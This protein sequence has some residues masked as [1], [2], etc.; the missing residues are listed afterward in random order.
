[1]QS[2][3][4]NRLDPF[5]GQGAGT[6][7]A[8]G[9][10]RQSLWASFLKPLAPLHNCRTTGLQGFGN[11]PVGQTLRS[12]QADACTQ[13]GPLGTSFGRHPGFQ[14]FAILFR[15]RQFFGWVPHEPMH[16]TK[17]DNCKDIIVTLH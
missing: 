2:S 13:D 5:G 8:G 12:L 14:G 15:Y 6:Q 11:G 17:L 7:A 9:I 1:M 3:L 10:F 16:N 4:H